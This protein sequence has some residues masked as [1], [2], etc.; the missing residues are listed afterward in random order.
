[1]TPTSIALEECFSKFHQNQNT[2]HKILFLI[3]DG[4]NN[5]GKDPYELIREKLKHDELKNVMIVSCYF[6]S[7]YIENP[8]K[9]YYREPE[10]INEFCKKL[11][12]ISSIVPVDSPGLRILA[13]K[14]HWELPKERVCHLFFQVNH[15]DIINEISQVLS[16]FVNDQ[17]QF[18]NS[19]S[20]IYFDMI[21]NDQL[22]NQKSFE[23]IRKT[24]YAYACSGAIQ[25]ALCRIYSREIP[26]FESIVNP[27]IKKH[28]YD[29]GNVKQVLTENCPKYGLHFNILK[30]EN[31]ARVAL[32]LGRAC[33]GIFNLP[34]DAWDKFSKFFTNN[35]KG[36]LKKSDLL[37]PDGTLGNWS[38]Y[39]GHAVI[40]IDANI[41]ALE[42]LN[43]WGSDW[44][45]KGRFRIENAEVLDLL[46]FDIYW[47][48]NDLTDKEKD[49][50]QRAVNDTSKAIE[51]NDP[52]SDK[53]YALY[54]ICPHCGFK[55]KS[56]KF[57]NTNKYFCYKCKK[58][59]DPAKLKFLRGIYE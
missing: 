17:N 39:S 24:C 27:I 10:K 13:N 49:N 5:Q 9:L 43:S 18:M 25:L 57:I 14:Y 1:M 56:D 3:T 46:F 54:L 35:P 37:Q 47:T 32:A 8:R 55:M 16:D 22:N 26:S 36:I 28:G 2:K 42:F 20:S 29:G 4:Q 40:L 45:N 41:V 12:D 48:L 7:S 23:Q 30:N 33:V 58:D 31:E 53:F 15:P 59:I 38:N 44:G 50:Y 51:N 6:S 52:D 19:F 34:N 11:F 21:K